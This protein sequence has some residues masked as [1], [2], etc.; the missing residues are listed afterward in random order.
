MQRL[1]FKV[2]QVFVVVISR[3]AGRLLA[4]SRGV[5]LEE[6]VR[7]RVKESQANSKRVQLSFFIIRGKLTEQE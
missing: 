3:S 7:T 2:G 4:A 5:L 6:G 1:D